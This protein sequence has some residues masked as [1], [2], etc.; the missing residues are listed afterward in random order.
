MSLTMCAT[1]YAQGSFQPDSIIYVM[2]K[3]A[4]WQWKELK[5]NG[6]RHSKTDWTNG[7]MYAGMVALAKV[8]NNNTY[9]NELIKVGKENDWGLGSERFFADDYCVGQT[10]AQLFTVFNDPDY[11]AKFRARA[12]TIVSLPHTESL[13]WKNNVQNREWAWCDA[14]FMGPPSLGYLFQATGEKKYIN[15]ASKLWWKTSDY[16]YDDKEHLFYRDSRYFDKKEKNGAKVFWSRGN[17]WVM[18]GLVRILEVMPKN[19][20]D[21]K[22]FEKQF[23]EMSKKIV[24]L[25]QKDG[26]WHASLLDPASFPVKETSGTGFFAYALAW[27]IN[28]GLLSYKAYHTAVQKSWNAL[29]SSIHPDGKLGFVQAI[30]ADPQKVTYDDSEVYGVGAFLLAGSEIF[31][32]ELNK[33]SGLLVGVEN[34]LAIN[35]M[36]Q[37][38]EISWETI[39]KKNK[40]LNEANAIV[41]DAL[42]GEQVPSQVIYNGSTKPQGLIFQVNI[43][44]GTERFFNIKS[45]HRDNYP[46]KVYGRQVPERFDDFAWENDRIAFRMYGAA[47]DSQKDNAKGIDVWSKKT[48]RLI[49]NEWYK[50]GDYHVDHGQGMDGYD[51]GISLGAGNSTPF[52]DGKFVFSSNYNVY[53]VVDQGPI[54]FTFDLVYNAWDVNGEK[55]SQRKRISLDAG[56]SLNQIVDN[57]QF[58]SKK[59]PIAT[60][61]TKHND[62]GKQKIDTINHYISYWDKTAGNV[63]NGMIGVGIV[64]PENEHVKLVDQAGHLLGL[65]NIDKNKTFIYYQGAAWNRSGLFS[66]EG[67]WLTYLKNFSQGLETPLV[68]EFNF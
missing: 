10:Y 39:A 48:S 36:A 61:L 35:R 56:S 31:R 67:D 24:S 14:L 30:G 20:P 23:E 19:H 33:N 28:H 8:V 29:I 18:G 60:G 45:G 47:L 41:L 27:G 43:Q 2:K 17:G 53:K 5:E 59:L 50:K 57:Y 62:D 65:K 12:D 54:R 3:T 21:R 4:D 22:K 37:T 40:Q 11:I 7:A 64:F 26:S 63:D 68:I 6:W 1:V 46:V 49:V 32:M 44:P 58:S 38:V 51:V 55:V 16:L 15:T 66:Q 9:Y 52:I 13:L 25:Q 34:T 42:T